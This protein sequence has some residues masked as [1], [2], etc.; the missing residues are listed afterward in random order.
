VGR[1]R[2]LDVRCARRAGASWTQIG[3]ALGTT[4]QAAWES[5]TRWIEGQAELHRGV[6]MDEEWAQ[7]ERTLTGELDPGPP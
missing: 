5:H 6:D 2:Q 7:A 4:K 3:E 1:G